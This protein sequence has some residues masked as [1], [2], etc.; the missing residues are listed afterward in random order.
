MRRDNAADP[1]LPGF[2]AIGINPVTIEA[3]LRRRIART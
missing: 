1:G 3:E 2:A